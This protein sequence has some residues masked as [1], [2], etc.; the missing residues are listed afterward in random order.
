MCIQN[1]ICTKLQNFSSKNRLAGPMCSVTVLFSLLINCLFHIQVQ[2]MYRKV[3]QSNHVCLNCFVTTGIV[4]QTSSTFAAQI[5]VHIKQGFSHLS[6]PLT[7]PSQDYTLFGYGDFLGR[8]K[9]EVPSAIELKR[10]PIAP[11]LII[12]FNFSPKWLVQDNIKGCDL[13]SQKNHPV[14]LCQPFFQLTVNNC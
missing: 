9:S 5:F 13:C 12:W 2:A 3:E 1:I 7:S 4:P 6:Q 14:R 8:N 11:D 10:P